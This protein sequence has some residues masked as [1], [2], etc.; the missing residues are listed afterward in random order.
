MTGIKFDSGKPDYSLIP[1]LAQDEFV[2]VLTFGA[3][4]YGRGNWRQL[5]DLYHRYI[6]A[7]GRHLNAMMRGEI[8]DLE[9]GLLHAAHLQS[10]AAFIAEYQL[11]TRADK[12]DPT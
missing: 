12:K 3:S 5:D 10:C 4:K 6:A 11:A 2:K 7:A 8:I 1:P 9:S